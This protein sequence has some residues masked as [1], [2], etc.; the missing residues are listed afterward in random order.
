FRGRV[1]GVLGVNNRKAGRSRTREDLMVIMA[2][3]DYA[4]IAIENAQLYH[5]SEVERTQFETVLT[6]TENA[7]IVLDPEHRLLLINQAARERS[8]VDGAY[9][10]RAIVEAL[11][12]PR[13][14]VVIR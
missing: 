3:A 2:M 9:V 5:R 12:G 4:A 7:V 8:H 6:E 11:G 14:P 1:S 10:G 13:V